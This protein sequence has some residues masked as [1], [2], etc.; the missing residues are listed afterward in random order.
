MQKWQ[1]SEIYQAVQG[2]GRWAGWPCTI[3]RLQGCN[4]R[5][6]FCDTPQALE[7]DGG[8]EYDKVRL[9][10]KIGKV[11]RKGFI[12][13][14]G[15][16]PMIQDVTDL[17][18]LLKM[19]GDVHLETNGTLPVQVGF[20]WVTVSPKGKHTV[21]GAIERANEIKWL[22]STRDDVIWLTDFLSQWADF[23]GIVSVQPVSL[24]NQATKIAY[25]AVLDYG[26]HLSL[27]TH[28]LI[29]VQ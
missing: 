15:G 20:D 10:S 19:F 3:V 6:D 9:V 24:D 14:T 1:V 23:D 13:L 18:P 26:W 5:C 21:A 17:I 7:K 11:H 12:L 8:I 28:R 27:Q 25:Q 29:G 4:L 22:V 16:E 2:E